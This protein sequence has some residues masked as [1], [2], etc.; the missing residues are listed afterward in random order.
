MNIIPLAANPKVEKEPVL[1][2]QRS[3]L[4]KIISLTLGVIVAL[5][6]AE[7]GLRIGGL[8]YRL[9]QHQGNEFSGDGDQ[10]TVL[11]LG[12]SST[13]LG[14]SYAYPH[15]LETL[16]EEHAEGRQ[17]E[18]INA[19]MPGVDSL[20]IL[21]NLEANLERY[22]PD[23]VTVQM[24]INDGQKAFVDL[25]LYADR[26][27]SHR[28]LRHV[29]LYRMIRYLADGIS[30]QK[31]R[32][33]EERQLAEEERLALADIEDIGSAREYLRLGRLYRRQGKFE[34]AEKLLKEA[35]V[36]DESPRVYCDLARIYHD[37]DR[38]LE[39]ESYYRIALETYPNF[40]RTYRWM[41]R[42]LRHQAR[43]DEVEPLLL[44][45]VAASGSA[46][47]YTELAKCYRGDGRL[48]EAEQA[49]RTAME[50]EENPYIPRDLGAMLREQGRFAE[51]EELF[52]R[53]LA[54]WPSRHTWV[55]LARLYIETDRPD[56][57]EAAYLDALQT[58]DDEF[59]RSEYAWDARPHD[60]YGAHVELARFYK[61]RGQD[62]EARELLAE[63]AP[64]DM[65]FHSY[66][67]VIDRVM[68]EVGTLVVIQYPVRSIE[69][70][71]LMIPEQEGVFFVD[72]ESS[73]KDGIRAN[74]FNA[75]FVDHYAGDFGHTSELGHYLVACNTAV[76][77]IEE[78]FGIGDHS[79]DCSELPTS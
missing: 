11:C 78:I 25:N 5:S 16:L 70:L 64:N 56:A 4:E 22:Q 33:E 9:G 18:V 45:F 2:R 54:L 74:G 46:M 15:Q 60:T 50:I 36:A 67:V 52:W 42:L 63:I 32:E 61:E 39:E 57:A 68:A 79:L 12:E 75:Y 59:E 6:A 19:G 44:E 14:G 48:Q 76:V 28:L 23:I 73:F 3:L 38:P 62:K 17:F 37:T 72:N 13:A 27:T 1:A 21:H 55:E 71:E 29:K 34:E 49:Y 7:A 10:L 20:V 53:S 66:D 43:N 58:S 51:A 31:L 8:V 41:V 40:H 26:P 24:G 47:A 69:P 77:F 35:L 30:R 65:T